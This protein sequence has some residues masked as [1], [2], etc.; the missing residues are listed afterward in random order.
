MSDKFPDDPNDPIPRVGVIDVVSELDS[1]DLL[2]GLIIAKPLPPNK[3]A[4]GRLVQKVENY[5]R[6]L[7]EA[8]SNKKVRVDI[9][10]HPATEAASMKVIKECGA[11]LEQHSIQFTISI[12]DPSTLPALPS[13]RH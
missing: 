9:V 12:Q 6:E 11:W 2:C 7:G 10:V 5:I 8:A 13:T 3:Q 1:G 4:L